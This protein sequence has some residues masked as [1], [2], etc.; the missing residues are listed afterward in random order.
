MKIT[1]NGENR[2]L[3]VKTAV[4]AIVMVML[5]WAAF[6]VRPLASPLDLWTWRNPLPTANTLNSI[7][8]GN[9][10]YVAVGQY[11]AIA[12]SADGINW[13]E[14]VAPVNV[15]LTAVTYAAGVFVAVG[16]S[17][18][19]VTMNIVLTSVDGV[20]WVQNAQ[21]GG[22]GT[23]GGFN[24]VAYGGGN[25]VAVGEAGAVWY[26]SDG[27]A[28]WNQASSGTSENL[29]AV[30]Y[31]DTEF[32]AGGDNCTILSSPNGQSWTAATVNSGNGESFQGIAYGGGTFVAVG[33]YT[34]LF[35]STDGHTWNQST[36]GLFGG[37]VIYADVNGSGEFIVAQSTTYSINTSSGGIHW[38]NYYDP[39]FNS[40][41]SD[42]NNHFVGIGYNVIETNFTD[43]SVSGDWANVLE[44]PSLGALNA[45][46]YGTTAA[47]TNLFVAGGHGDNQLPAIVTSTNGYRWQLDTNSSIESFTTFYNAY[48]TG[49]A[50]G[51]IPQPMFVATVNTAGG[52]TPGVDSVIVSSSNAVVWATGYQT[53]ISLDAIVY[54][55]TAGF[56]AVGSDGK[57]VSS[58]NLT[59]WTVNPS[60]TSDALL[61][62]TFGQG[63]YVAVGSF[64]TT[65]WSSDGVSWNF[66]NDGDL[67][68]NN[69][70][71]VAYGNGLFVAVGSEGV[72]YT[73][74]NGGQSWTAQNSGTSANFNGVTFANGLFVA[75]TANYELGNPVFVSPDGINWTQSTVG[76][77]DSL[78]AVASGNY[79]YIAVGD[80]GAVLGSS[81]AA[82]MP[83]G[84]TYSGG[85][86]TLTVT[87]PPGTYG[88]YVSRDLINWTWIEN[89]TFTPS[90]PSQTAT[91][92]GAGDFMDGYYEL[93]PPGP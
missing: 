93:G 7:T 57:T 63:L 45:I 50:F 5:F 31:G 54:G 64:G 51:R 9:G 70:N 1:V 29:N 87:G 30:A 65:L 84:S 24:D 14:Q 76:T 66:V 16:V 23:S 15:N 32:E 86:F 90:S 6:P 21:A 4:K 37:S 44:N 83:G 79:Q 85:T 34:G 39:A 92:T 74:S 20:N 53:G 42:G 49:I 10:G 58:A 17:A 40:I 75:V 73:S 68:S 41:T 38:T 46:V 22:L 47:G 13:S 35:D 33:S 72:V 77:A 82:I 88:V 11:G 62:I 19:N 89:V 80:T 27:G 48:V 3:I 91:D 18:T 2:D 59:T 55:P 69:L 28:I 61:A 36:N 25:F 56:V 8:Y 12:T 71:G 67:G 60:G 43:I 26:S 81:L 52:T 78:Y